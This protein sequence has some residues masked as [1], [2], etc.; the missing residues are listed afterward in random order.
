M[1]ALGALA[2]GEPVTPTVYE[3]PTPGSNPETAPEIG[4]VVAVVKA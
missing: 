2:N 4:D 1:N 3:P